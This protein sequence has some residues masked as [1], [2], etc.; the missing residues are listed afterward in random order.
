MPPFETCNFVAAEVFF[1]PPDG[2]HEV[3]IELGDEAIAAT[4]AVPDGVTSC[5]GVAECVLEI[6]AGSDGCG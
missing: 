3:R 2:E 6:E 1:A 4:V 5:E